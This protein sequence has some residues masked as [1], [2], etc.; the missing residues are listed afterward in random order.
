MDTNQGFPNLP[1]AFIN[2]KTGVLTDVAYRFLLTLW[3]RTGGGH[4]ADIVTVL[5][6]VKI[7][8][9]VQSAAQIYDLETRLS[10]LENKYEAILD[11]QSNDQSAFL[12]PYS[13]VSGLELSQQ[14]TPN[15]EFLSSLTQFP[16]S[17]TGTW[18]PVLT[19]GTAPTG[20]V[21]VRQDGSWTKISDFCFFTCDVEISGVGVGGALSTNITG[22]PWTAAVGS[23]VVFACLTG[24]ITLTAGYSWNAISLLQ[25]STT[26]RLEECGSA[27]PRQ[28]IQWGAVGA[29]TRIKVSGVY[30]TKQE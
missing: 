30:K 22:L 20:V 14:P 11:Q 1:S 8:D 10:A 28:P 26:L 9:E 18:T 24:A 5:D 2:P 27:V 7:Q 17:Q 13:E 4:G 29:T 25:N 21:F 16:I 12:M 23:D 6:Q 19:A 15:P 3:Q